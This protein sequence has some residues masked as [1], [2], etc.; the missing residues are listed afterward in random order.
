[1]SAGALDKQLVDPEYL[2][3]AALTLL[4][5]GIPTLASSTNEVEASLCRAYHLLAADLS[6]L[7]RLRQA[8]AAVSYPDLFAAQRHEKTAALLYLMRHQ[9]L[10]TAPSEADAREILDA[11]RDLS[12]FIEALYRLEAFDAFAT[13]F[14]F[15]AAQPRDAGNQFWAK[16]CFRALH[17]MAL[18]TE[19]QPRLLLFLKDR[20]EARRSVEMLMSS[21][22]AGLAEAFRAVGDAYKQARQSG[23]L[24]VTPT[25]PPYLV[26]YQMYDQGP[27][28]AGAAGLAAL[29]PAQ[30]RIRR[31]AAAGD[32][33]TLL[34]WL[35][36]GSD[37]AVSATLDAARNAFPALQYANLLERLIDTPE[38]HP[39]RQTAAVLDISDINRTMNPDGGELALNGLLIKIA[40]T[41]APQRA[42]VARVAVRELGT[43][44]AFNE[45]LRIV[46]EAPIIEAAEEAIVVLRNLRRLPLAETP[47]RR[48]PL[49]QQAYQTARTQLQQIE[50]LTEQAWSC[51]SEEMA[52][53][54][55]DRLKALNARPELERLSQRNNR[56]SEL[57]KRTLSELRLLNA[58]SRRM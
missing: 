28:T 15:A 56:V 55:M 31:A 40:L 42:G 36:T 4:D 39:V 43:I 47:V 14:D 46:E 13:L 9:L 16:V 29:L 45:A 57:A 49:L 37:P 3:P 41:D 18:L 25:A 10:D 50:S 26:L 32:S 17:L 24:D 38:A 5:N 51:S 52:A 20:P 54:Y 44:G 23:V 8:G 30:E 2:I 27:R 48:R 7:D 53:V 33:D 34:A 12:A 1:M 58:R 6:T 35:L 19:A 22:D 21:P 11:R